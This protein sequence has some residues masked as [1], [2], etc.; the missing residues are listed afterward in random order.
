[1]AT[2]QE[3][4]W[5]IPSRLWGANGYRQVEFYR[6]A[7]FEYRSDDFMEEFLEAAEAENPQ[8]LKDAQ[9]MPPT[10]GKTN[11]LFQSVHGC[12]Y[13]AAASLCCREPGFPDRVLRR[14]EGE[15]ATMV[16]RKLV[17]GREYAWVKLPPADGKQAA[18]AWK[19]LSSSGRLILPGEEFLP[20]SPVPLADG[21][22]IFCGYIPASSSQTYE[23]PPEDLTTPPPGSPGGET[24]PLDLPIE[25]L[26]SR[27]VTPLARG[28]NNAPSLLEKIS[29]DIAAR[30][31]SVYLLVD[32]WEFLAEHLPD[33][34]CALAP[35]ATGPSSV[36]AGSCPPAGPFT[37][38]K[39]AEKDAL[40]AFLNSQTYKGSLTLG[41]ALKA[42]AEKYNKLNAAGGANLD[43]EGFTIL[44]FSL[45]S[46]SSLDNTALDTLS[47]RV[48][49]ALP[50]ERPPLQAPKLDISNEV[51]YVLRFVYV[52]PE[53]DPPVAQVSL[54]SQPFTFAPFF[55]PDAPA[56]PVKI[57]LPT[58]VSIAGLRKYK[59]NVTFLMSDGMRKKMN[60]LAGLENDLLKGPITPNVDSDAFAFICQFSIQIIF[61]VAFMLLLVFVVVFN[62]IFWWM[63][64]FKICLPVPKKF[65]PDG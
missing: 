48:G 39:A 56:R 37:G 24:V 35:A 9:L 49:A 63:A 53:C 13:L 19:P 54:P 60:A 57:P 14:A 22:Q 29:D 41:M 27:F 64:F 11:K 42:V 17:S 52:R 45:K 31:T 34:A 16:L 51:Q 62:L 47:A 2:V 50:A 46:G 20:A 18:H 4:D 44:A 32:L 43:T 7:L 36:I 21:R 23:I 33:V 40:L 58:D 26:N 3:F 38:E 12:F 55:D 65:L 8:A 10:D 6:P 15:R 28:K 5:L 30:D 59:K 1:M 61:I 25:E